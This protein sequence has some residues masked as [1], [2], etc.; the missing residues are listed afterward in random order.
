MRKT[1]FAIALLL[2]VAGIVSAQ[3]IWTPPQP[4][5]IT[6]KNGLTV[7][8]LENR[9]LPVISMEVMVKAGS[10]TDP[11]GYAGLANFAAEMLPKGTSSRSALDIAESF[12]YV[13]AQFSVKC[14]YDAIFFSLTTLARDFDKTAP[15]LF[16]LLSQPAFDSIETGRLQGE[17]LSAIEAKGDRPNTQSA[18]AFTQLLFG[19]HPYAHPVMGSAESVSRIFRHDLSG[20]HKK[21]YAPNNCIISV[22]GD[23]KSSRIKKLIEQ[24]LGKWPKREIPGLRLPEIPAIGQSR[25]LLINRQINQAYINL[26]FLGPKRDDPDYQA[27]R[28]MN[29]ILGGGGFVSRL[30]KNIRMA[31]GLAYDVDSYYDPRSDFGPYILSVQTKCASA[32]TAVKSLITEMRLI[33]NQPVSDEELKEAKDYIRGSYPFRFETSGQTA[34]QFLYVELYNLGAGYFRQDMEKT[35]AVTKDDVMAAAK[36]YLKPDNFLLAMVTDT[37]QTKLN[38]PGLKIE[39]Q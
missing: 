23:F 15:V 38:I 1:V 12:D 32:D 20:H 7:L 2:A 36:K 6:L 14:D 10:I 34:R 21:Y 16:D 35:L 5:K 19:G 27:I 22:V 39:K 31:Q 11:A 3:G 30:V 26:G 4:K 28:V 37:S 18:E 17:L 9:Q 33:Q 13:G 29:Y 25:A 24:N 8:L